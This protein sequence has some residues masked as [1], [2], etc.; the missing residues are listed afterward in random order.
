MVFQN[1]Q[2]SSLAYES[3]IRTHQS[4]P[5]KPAIAKDLLKADILTRIFS[6]TDLLT[7]SSNFGFIIQN[8]EPIALRILDFSSP[9]DVV[10][11]QDIF[12]KWL[13]GSSVNH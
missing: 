5:C 13:E 11:D 7:N 6:L 8:N 1:T 2:N 10:I 3:F 9:D 12:T 4:Y